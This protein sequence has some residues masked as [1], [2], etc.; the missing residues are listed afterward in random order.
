[1]SAAALEKLK[2][3]LGDAV[4]STHAEH[5]DETAVVDAARI[6]EICTF[7]RD[8]PDLKFTMLVDLTVLDTLGLDPREAGRF[9]VVYHLRSMATG[10]RLR[11]KAPIDLAPDEGPAL[12]DSVTSVWK[13]ANW[14]EREAWDM[15]GVH[16]R[17]HPK[18]KRILMYEEFVGHP[19]RKD[20]PKDR[21]QPLIR[22]DFS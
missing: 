5:G 4:R 16:F 6:V 11:L 9:E 7:L 12:I 8:D 19:L 10:K 22:R 20:Y 1:M 15:F 2:A 3:K 18:L 13:G 14:F 21:R 17:G